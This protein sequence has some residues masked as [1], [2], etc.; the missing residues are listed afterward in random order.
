MAVNSLSNRSTIRTR[1]SPKLAMS[2]F[3]TKRPNPRRIFQTEV[4]VFYAVSEIYSVWKPAD[5]G[6]EDVGC[7]CGP[8]WLAPSS[9]PEQERRFL[10]CTGNGD[11]EAFVLCD[12]EWSGR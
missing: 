11:P 10:L 6:L 7:G 9:I 8:A 5:R 2:A 4:F 1:L 3:A 12:S